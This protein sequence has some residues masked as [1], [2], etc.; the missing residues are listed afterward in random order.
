MTIAREKSHSSPSSMFESCIVAN[1]G[2]Y[3]L[4]IGK[5][6]QREQS[7][8]SQDLTYESACQNVDGI[9]TLKFFFQFV[10]CGM[11]INNNK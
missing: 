5:S 8:M 6:F 11:C 10:P 9:E 3:V 2:P 1:N 7:A 4:G